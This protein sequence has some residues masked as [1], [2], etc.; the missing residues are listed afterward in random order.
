MGSIRLGKFGL[1]LGMGS[2]T[3]RVCGLV[4]R[5]HVRVRLA[6]SPVR[7]STKVFSLP[8]TKTVRSKV[9]PVLPVWFQ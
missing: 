9:V 2:G 3:E 8:G 4:P 6:C 5:I 1:G 7:G